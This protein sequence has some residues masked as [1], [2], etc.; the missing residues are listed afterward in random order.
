MSPTVFLFRK[1]HVATNY[2]KYRKRRAA[3]LPI[4]EKRRK[5][6]NILLICPRL[7]FHHVLLFRERISTDAEFTIS[8][9]FRAIRT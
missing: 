6:M 3:C 4:D 7:L 1:C 9:S 2:K 5:L 8:N